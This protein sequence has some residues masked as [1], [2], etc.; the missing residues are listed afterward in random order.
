LGGTFA[1]DNTSPFKRP[2]LLAEPGATFDG[3]DGLS[4]ALLDQ[5]HAD[6]PEIRHHAY[7]L[8]LPFAE[9]AA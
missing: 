1:Q 8:C 2:I 5:V 7:H 4:G 6:R 9:T 3:S